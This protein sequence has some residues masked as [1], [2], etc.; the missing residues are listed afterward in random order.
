VN[1]GIDELTFWNGTELMKRG[2]WAEAADHFYRAETLGYRSA[3]LPIFLGEALVRSGQFDKAVVAYAEAVADDP[4]FIW[5]ATDRAYPHY[6]LGCALALANR[7]S[8]AIEHLEES[9]RLRPQLVEAQ[10]ALAMALSA[11]GRVT[12]S[13]VAFDRALALLPSYLE[14][15]PVAFEGAFFFE[16]DTVRE[17]YAAVN[18]A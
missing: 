6:F 13:R 12:E 2:A 14:R 5:G 18:K 9:L 10:G 15:W 4:F 16:L 8:E 7:P 3:V 17:A 1:I 11:L